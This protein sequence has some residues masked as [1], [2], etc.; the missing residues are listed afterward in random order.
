MEDALDR[1]HDELSDLFEQNLRLQVQN[2]S[3]A[4]KDGIAL[5]KNTAPTY[6]SQH[7]HHSFHVAPTANQAPPV[8]VRKDYDED[9]LETILRH[10]HVD[11]I[12]LS[13]AQLT[14]F[15]TAPHEHQLQLLELWRTAPMTV[16]DQQVT[17]Y[18]LHTTLELEKKLAL[19]RFER[20][21]ADAVQAEHDESQYRIDSLDI[22]RNEIEVTPWGEVEPCISAGH[23]AKSAPPRA[24]YNDP[25]YAANGYGLFDDT[26]QAMQD[27][28]LA[29][30][31][32]Q[33]KDFERLQAL[34]R[35][36]QSQCDL[37]MDMSDEIE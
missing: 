27:R 26:A 1:S 17:A 22:A 18:F 35:Q 23:G 20:Q 37:S 33:A 14:L 2:P 30:Q 34:Y 8:E 32:A 6:I 10:H 12:S 19:E 25:V 21:Q 29:W 5:N 28:H 13:A 36:K 7:Y 3:V 24:S 11:P 16:Q 31:N 9:T 4:R 15:E